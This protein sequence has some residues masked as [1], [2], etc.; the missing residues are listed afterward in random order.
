MKNFSKG[1]PLHTIER[2]CMCSPEAAESVRRELYSLIATLD[3]AAC[4]YECELHYVSVQKPVCR[5]C[6]NGKM[7]YKMTDFVN[8]VI[9]RHLQNPDY[10]NQLSENEIELFRKYNECHS[11]EL[12]EAVVDILKK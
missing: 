10:C 3:V 11:P 8:T 7:L 9:D 1:I 6:E 5:L 4:F 12:L 2:E